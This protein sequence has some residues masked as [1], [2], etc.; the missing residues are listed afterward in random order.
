MQGGCGFEWIE[1]GH[2]MVSAISGHRF[3]LLFAFK[4]FMF[5]AIQQASEFD[6]AVMAQALVRSRISPH[7]PI[8]GMIGQL[9]ENGDADK[10]K[11]RLKVLF[12][13][14]WYP[15][16]EH[17]VNGIFVKEH[18]RAASL[19]NDIVVLY[20][21]PDP[22]PQFKR[23]YLISEAVEEGI[24]TIR[25]KYGGIVLYLVSRLAIWKQRQGDLF[26]IKFKTDIFYKFLATP[27]IVVRDLVYYRRLFSAFRKLLK[28]GWKPDIIHAHV[29]IAG[30]PAILLGKLFN[31][32]VVINER[33]SGFPLRKLTILQRVKA[34]FALSRAQ[35]ILPTSNYLRRHIEAYGIKNKFEVIPNAINPDIFSPPPLHDDGQAEK[36][37]KLL[38]VALLT[39]IKGI[40]YLLKVLNQIR[41]QRQDFVLDIVGDGPNRNEYEEL[42][43]KLGLA[44]T[45]R[46]HGLKPKGKV[47]QFMRNCDFFVMPSLQET[48][49][50][51]YIEAMACGKPVIAT[52]TGG[53]EEIVNKEVGILVPPCDVKALKKA[54]E[55][56]LDN[57]ASYSSERIAGYAR[58]RFSYATVGKLLDKVYESTLSLKNNTI[59]SKNH[60]EDMPYMKKRH[61]KGI[62]TLEAY[63]DY[64]TRSGYAWEK[65][66]SI[67]PRENWD[68][69][70]RYL[71]YLRHLA[72]YMF[73]EEFVGNKSVLE[74]GCGT[75]FGASHLS[76]VAS[77]IVA[78]DIWQAGIS[79]CQSQYS[80]DSNLTFIVA[81][82]GKLP[83]KSEQFDVAISFHV[84]EHIEPKMVLNYLIE[85][86]RVLKKGGR[87]VV[88]T[89]NSRIRLLPF[90]KPLNPAHKKEYRD[91]ELMKLLG[92]VFT[93][94]K[95]FGLCG[96]DEIQDIERNRLKQTPFKAYV[97][98]PIYRMLIHYLPSPMRASLKRIKQRFADHHT[99]YKPISQ[100]T[101]I[102]RFSVNDFRLDPNCPKDCRDLYGICTKV[103]D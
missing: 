69:L 51:V 39:P 80:G 40:P 93:M 103:I 79:L 41:E 87:F 54:I 7:H 78:T 8:F 9:R 70:E 68:S 20:A 13:P 63:T 59:S 77:S 52:S 1:N 75:G 5:K 57:Y 62:E 29:F 45:V 17:T 35:F 91:N 89:P 22:S 18:A 99:H 90:Q 60:M 61:E 48:F 25:I 83:F 66:T 67:L 2:N 30:V 15:S 36:S 88:S 14:A 85:I 64:L 38:L 100:D 23:P 4:S 102:A 6:K 65:G 42:A 32:P 73:A 43:R 3:V 58:E 33:W 49:G 76:K 44:K 26:E 27:W 37:I 50:V 34:K 98:R 19:Y 16:K 47:A 72:E 21:Y 95:V 94:V 71:E 97:V 28:E 12:L 81:D 84:I 11:P 55:Y 53:P 92:G 86:K 82:G 24:R 31:I 74:I 46:F 101:F 56:M 96:S 10:M